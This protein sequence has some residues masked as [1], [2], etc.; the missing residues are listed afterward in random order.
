MYY[1]T[2]TGLVLNLD[3]VK[4][5]FIAGLVLPRSSLFLSEKNSVPLERLKHRERRNRQVDPSDPLRALGP[6]EESDSRAVPEKEADQE[7]E[8]LEDRNTSAETRRFPSEDDPWDAIH[9]RS[10]GSPRASGV[11]G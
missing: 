8:W 1:S 6:E 9:A 11:V 5:R 3:G 4:Q 7:L 2:K 10:P